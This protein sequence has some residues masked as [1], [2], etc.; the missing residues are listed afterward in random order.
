MALY[1]SIQLQVKDLNWAV[2][3][4]YTTP[5]VKITFQCKE[6]QSIHYLYTCHLIMSIK[7]LLNRE[8]LFLTWY[9]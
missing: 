1:I 8:S 3:E 4:V 9:S 5:V 2:I 6:K 7:E